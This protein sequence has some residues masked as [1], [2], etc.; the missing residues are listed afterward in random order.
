M[1]LSLK[2]K[3]IGAFLLIVSCLPI[4]GG[5]GLYFSKQTSKKYARIVQMNVSGAETFEALRQSLKDLVQY[6]IW[7]ALPENTKV[8]FEKATEKIQMAKKIFENGSSQLLD[9]SATLQ[10]KAEVDVLSKKW[11]SLVLLSEKVS[12][13]AAENDPKNSFEMLKIL[14][15]SFNSAAEDYSD[16]LSILAESRNKRIDGYVADTENLNRTGF[17]INLGIVISGFLLALALGIQFASSLAKNLNT[18]AGKLSAEADEMNLHSEQISES[19]SNVSGM[20][21]NSAASLVQ[22]SGTFDEI[23]N[24][25]KRSSKNAEQAVALAEASATSAQVG[26][27][28]MIGLFQS[29]KEISTSSNKISSIVSLIDGISFQTNLLA[30]NAAV[31]AARAGEN[32]KGFAV[33]ADAVRS[34]AQKSAGAVKDIEVIINEIMEKI[35]LGTLQVDKSGVAIKNILQSVEKVSKISVDISSEIKQQVLGIDQV[36][37]A[38]KV[39]DG[40]TQNTARSAHE[41]TNSANLMSKQAVEL[42]DQSNLL[43]LIIAGENRYKKVR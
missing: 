32:G 29:M 11:S 38:L 40:S 24:V 37:S 39:I 7:Q 13:L 19:S 33:V 16:N 30:L 27:S 1:R 41:M 2:F 8:E 35:S 42:N 10:D 36:N 3:L 12:K 31:E 26:E 14:R 28:N 17:W 22:I 9:D 18:V 23:T 5:I 21:S 6:T 43:R 4:I 15:T 34:L 25:F 20:V